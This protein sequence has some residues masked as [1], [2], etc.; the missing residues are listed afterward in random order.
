[1]EKYM[2]CC[3]VDRSIRSLDVH[4]APVMN[5]TNKMARYN[6]IHSSRNKVR[7]KPADNGM[8]QRSRLI[9]GFNPFSW[10][11]TSVLSFFNKF[12]SFTSGAPINALANTSPRLER[13]LQTVPEFKPERA[14]S[15]L[16]PAGYIP[17]LST[18]RNGEKPNDIFGGFRQGPDGN[19]VT[20]S[21]I[22]AAMHRF[23]QSPTDIYKAVTKVAGGYRV[24]MRDDFALGLTDHELRLGARGARFVGADREMLKDAQFLYAVSA[25]RAQ[26]ENNDGTASSSFYAAM[27]SLNDREDELGPGE[28]FLRL[29][30]RKHM[31]T[32]SAHDLAR[33]LVGMSNRAG[34]SAAVI[35]G[36]EELW[37][38]R[39]RAPWRGDAIALV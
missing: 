33:G 10:L 22:K 34:H 37:G 15:K 20:V 9:A 23:G 38:T 26:M 19:C 27:R 35:N 29:G 5:T 39:G 36:R 30:L 16:D 2:R 14:T 12:S 1:M 7:Y 31:R 18:K 8:H 25:K 6:S 13:T 24:I 3:S 4:H 28:G 21:A 11:K 32:V 17:G